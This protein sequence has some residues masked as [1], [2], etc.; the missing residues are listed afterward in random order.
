MDKF[1]FL[2]D[3]VGSMQPSTW[4]TDNGI[5]VWLYMSLLFCCFVLMRDGIK[6]GFFTLVR[7]VLTVGTMAFAVFSM[8]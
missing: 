2:M 4:I 3:V 7:Y 5:P 6:R 8:F 1:N